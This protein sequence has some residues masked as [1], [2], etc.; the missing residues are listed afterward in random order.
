ME[1]MGR[2]AIH[3]ISRMTAAVLAVSACL[4]LSVSCGKDSIE[5][6]RMPDEIDNVLLIYMAG[7]ANNLAVDMRNNIDD[8]CEGYVPEGADRNILLAYEELTGSSKPTRSY[9]IRIYRYKGDVV[10]DTLVTYPV[11]SIGASAATLADVLGETARRFPAKGYGLLFSS[12]A[13]GWL[14][15]GYYSDPKQYDRE[16]DNMMHS[17]RTQRDGSWSRHAEMPE[18]VPYIAPEYAPGSPAVKS[19]GQDIVSENGQEMAYEM[20]LKDFA[21]AI[22]MHLDYI[23]FD[24]CLMGCVEVAYEL[25]DK[26]DRI[27][28]SPTEVLA[29]GF[30][31]NTMSQRLLGGT[32]PDLL[33][34]CRDYFAKYDAMSGDYRSATITCVDCT[35]IGPLADACREI[36]NTHRDRLDLLDGDGIQQY[37]RYDYHWFY[38]LRDIAVQAGADEEELAG[39]DEALDGCILYKDATEEFIGIPIERY[40]GF[41]MYLPGNGSGYLDN[42]YR[43]LAWNKA[44]GLVSDS[45]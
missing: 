41:S 25:K 39:L 12:H 30:A 33:G 14:P 26:C 40:S 36:F 6:P 9:L 32:S 13:T 4:A 16:Y 17:S 11:T 5:P 38:D 10:R 29:Q 37:F 45:E 27:I 2:S 24:C 8:F 3:I 34:V 31:Y 28:F 21:D 23:L 18:R 20:D 43:S 19:V 35:G 44:T 15:I 7:K 22:P 1:N 42:Y